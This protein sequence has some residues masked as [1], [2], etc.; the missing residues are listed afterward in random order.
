MKILA[1]EL[2]MVTIIALRDY[3]NLPDT[4]LQGFTQIPEFNNSINIFQPVHPTRI[5]RTHSPEVPT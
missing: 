5:H 2:M 3:S 1:G 4:D